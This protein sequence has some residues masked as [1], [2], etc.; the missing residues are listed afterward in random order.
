MGKII[1]LKNKGKITIA[2]PV[3]QRGYSHNY[4]LFLAIWQGRLTVY[5]QS[6]INLVNLEQKIHG[7]ANNVWLKM[8]LIKFLVN[9]KVP[10]NQRYSTLTKNI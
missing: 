10:K 4:R 5:L 2:W 8:N 9:L 1:N 6:S 3:R 7:E